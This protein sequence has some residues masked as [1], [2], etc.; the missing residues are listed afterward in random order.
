MILNQEN[1]LSSLN[2]GGSFTDLS[3]IQ[4][5]DLHKNSLEKLPE[6]IGHLANLRVSYYFLSI[7]NLDCNSC[8]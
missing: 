6:D 1:D 3:E 2:G 7:D 8:C 5:I 4:V